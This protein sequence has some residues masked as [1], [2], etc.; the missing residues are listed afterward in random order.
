MHTVIPNN[1]SS[2]EKLRSSVMA[3]DFSL[4]TDFLMDEMTKISEAVPN[5]DAG[6]QG[7]I[8]IDSLETEELQQAMVDSDHQLLLLQKSK[9]ESRILSLKKTVRYVLGFG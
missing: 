4:I 2:V 7:D 1:L 5:L 3:E 8:M 9:L 6:P